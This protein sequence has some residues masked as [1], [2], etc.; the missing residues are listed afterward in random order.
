MH[1]LAHGCAEIVGK[2]LDEAWCHACENGGELVAADARQRFVWRKALGEH[3]RDASD[4]SLRSGRTV[5]VNHF[6]VPVDID[7]EQRGALAVCPDVGEVSVE[8]V[9]EGQ[10]VSAGR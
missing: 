2:A 10:A 1:L 8:V 6:A 3:F 5:W 7:Q 4:K 9:L